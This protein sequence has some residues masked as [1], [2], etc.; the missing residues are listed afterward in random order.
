[1]KNNRFPSEQIVFKELKE[2][3]KLDRQSL[4]SLD[5][6]LLIILGFQISV[7]FF[8]LANNSI[9]SL[10]VLNSTIIKVLLLNSFLLWFGGIFCAFIFWWPQNW[11]QNPPLSQLLDKFLYMFPNSD[12][13]SEGSVCRIVTHLK[14]DCEDNRKILLHKGKGLRWSLCLGA[15]SFLCLI[16][17]VLIK[18]M[19]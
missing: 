16:I 5:L 9:S 6:K 17:C 12:N 19:I 11:Q 1:M 8:L 13:N 14:K 7:F 2:R 10:L 4:F 3:R 18:H 15:G